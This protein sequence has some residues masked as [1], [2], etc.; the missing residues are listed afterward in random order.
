MKIP[1]GAFRRST[2]GLP[3]GGTCTAGHLDR[4][5]ENERLL[6][7]PAAPPGIGEEPA[8]QWPAQEIS[9]GRDLQGN[10]K[11]TEFTAV[12]PVGVVHSELRG[13]EEEAVE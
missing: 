7:L 12:F 1:M 5:E 13:Q 8:D 6:R 3:E 9:L 11:F 10:C 4:T 2:T